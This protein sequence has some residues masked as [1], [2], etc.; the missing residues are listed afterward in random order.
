MPN[1]INPNTQLDS[2][3]D[4]SALPDPSLGMSDQLLYGLVGRVS[5]IESQQPNTQV[6]VPQDSHLTPL[7]QIF[8]PGLYGSY[9]DCA[10]LSGIALPAPG[11]DW[12]P[13]FGDP[14]A[15]IIYYQI[16][17]TSGQFFHTGDTTDAR[18][19]QV[20]V[21]CVNSFSVKAKL[22]IESLAAGRVQLHVNSGFT[23]YTA[24]ANVTFTLRGDGQINVIT[25]I[26]NFGVGKCELR[27]PLWDGVT[28]F[29]VDP[30]GQNTGPGNTGSGPGGSDYGG[31]NVVPGV[32]GILGIAGSPAI[33]GGATGSPFLTVGAYNSDDDLGTASSTGDGTPV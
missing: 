22:I 1:D 18:M 2:P 27:G 30:H 17:S 24:S 14:S 33:I 10:S 9:W 3:I 26:T 12:L 7:S 23:E 28:A 19:A 21:Y 25:L 31:I 5:A 20:A 8:R 16:P 6:P 4:P 11:S 13:A 15:T 29:W 32:A